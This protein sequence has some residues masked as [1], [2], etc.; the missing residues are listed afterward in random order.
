MREWCLTHCE[1][2]GL[3]PVPAS[4]R[5]ACRDRRQRKIARGGATSAAHHRLGVEARCDLRQGIHDPSRSL[6]LPRLEEG[7]NLIVAG[8]QL[9]DRLTLAPRGCRCCYVAVDGLLPVPRSGKGMR[10]HVQR[11][12]RIWRNFRVTPRRHQPA[13]RQSWYVIRMD[14]VMCQP[15]MRRLL[16][17]QFFEYRSRLEPPAIRFVRGIFRTLAF[18]R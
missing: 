12:W 9:F 11:M 7:G 17:E 2:C 13:P 10:W 3:L 1:L 18:Q 15:R 4:Q 6:V 16:F 14:N 5:I 8:V